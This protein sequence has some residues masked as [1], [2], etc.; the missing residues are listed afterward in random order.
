MVI[1]HLYLANSIEHVQ[2]EG[3]ISNVKAWHGELDKAPMA[4][5]I[6]LVPATSFTH[7]HLT[8][9]TKSRVQ[10]AKTSRL[11]IDIQVV[12]IGITYFK[13]FS[14]GFNIFS[15]PNGVRLGVRY[16]LATRLHDAK[17]QGAD[18]H[19]RVIGDLLFGHMAREG[20]ERLIVGH[21]GELWKCDSSRWCE[22][23]EESESCLARNESVSLDV[24]VV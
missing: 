7:F 23:S 9:R 16:D 4:V 1:G 10:G 5:A 15:G 19:R 18:T 8:R 2:S 24:M 20:L 21:F 17:L 6:L 12:K 14:L 3:Y 13:I 11:A 22:L